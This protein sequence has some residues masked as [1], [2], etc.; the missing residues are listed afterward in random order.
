M[1]TSEFSA[2]FE[3]LNDRELADRVASGGLTVEAEAAAVSELVRRG[4]P[5][6]SRAE[7]PVADEGDYQGDM[8]I[9]ARYLTPTEA[10]MLCSCLN[11]GGV[12]AEAGDTNLVQAHSLLA[13][14]VGGASIR[15]PANYVAEARELIAAFKRGDFALDEDF[16]SDESS[17]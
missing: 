15:V 2:L 6:P 7:A 14:A 10:H 11:A 5:V 4:L 13:G 9:V 3:M 8:T 1:A 12:P 16:N 17:P